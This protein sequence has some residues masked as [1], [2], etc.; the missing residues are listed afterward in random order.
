LRT[1]VLVE[2]ISDQFALEALAERGGRDLHADG[3]SI[4]PMG[5]A[6]R[7]SVVPAW[8]RQVS[9]CASRTWRT[10]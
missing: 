3:I 8:N 10:S 5:G 6:T 9:T 4:A 1:V 2:G 7:T